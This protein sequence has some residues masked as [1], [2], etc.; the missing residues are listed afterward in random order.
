SHLAVAQSRHTVSGYVRDASTGETLIGAS[1]Q[2]K[3]DSETGTRANSY[4][5][6]SLT[7]PEGEHE[8]VVSHVGFRSYEF[9]I[10]LQADTTV[11]LT[12]TR[13]EVL[14][15]VVVSRTTGRDQV[16]DPQMG[17]TRLDVNEIKNVPVLLGE[18]D[19]LKTIQL[20]PGVVS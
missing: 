11:N 14:D 20:L 3:N 2:L 5:F 18:K 6:Y 15:E 8:F 13:G 7:L 1:I 19:V 16:A 4:G 10:R 17:I 9:H 12:L